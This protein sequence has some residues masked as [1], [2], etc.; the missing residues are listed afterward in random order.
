MKMKNVHLPTSSGFSSLDECLQHE[1]DFT[2][3]N[4]KASTYASS[5][6]GSNSQSSEMSVS[7]SEGS[8]VDP[9]S[10]ASAGLTLLNIAPQSSSIARTQTLANYKHH[11]ICHDPH[12]TLAELAYRSN[13]KLELSTWD[14]LGPTGANTSLFD[15]RKASK[16][17]DLGCF[18]GRLI[19]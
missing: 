1:Q 6:V 16:S 7:A 19:R 4:I 8:R 2:T 11:V 14:K 9:T 17:S 18:A 13:H 3:I 12:P 5:I 10:M 15:L